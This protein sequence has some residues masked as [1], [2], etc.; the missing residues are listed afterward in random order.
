MDRDVC[1]YRKN[2]GQLFGGSQWTLIKEPRNNG[3]RQKTNRAP[4]SSEYARQSL[5]IWWIAALPRY[6]KLIK[7]RARVLSQVARRGPSLITPGAV[8]PPSY[9]RRGRPPPL[10]GNRRRW[11]QWGG[12]GVEGGVCGCRRC[13]WLVAPQEKMR[14]DRWCLIFK[15]PCRCLTYFFVGCGKSWDCSYCQDC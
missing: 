7:R 4:L 5:S 1:A 14:V 8:L 11:K 15:C 12:M 9:P 2:R 6:R 3:T 10:L 13:D